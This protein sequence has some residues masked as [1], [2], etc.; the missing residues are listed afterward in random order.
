MRKFLGQVAVVAS[1]TLVVSVILALT[2]GSTGP[3]DDDRPAAASEALPADTSATADSGATSADQ[4]ATEVIDDNAATA[5]TPDH[6]EEADNPGD[7]STT[8]VLGVIVAQE[9]GSALADTGFAAI[10]V[11]LIAAI[12]T[13]FGTGVFYSSR[14]LATETTSS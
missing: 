11:L 14:R 10:P 1:L 3:A 7:D 8:E 5:G 4:A 13:I 6:L 2:T 9:S 12:L